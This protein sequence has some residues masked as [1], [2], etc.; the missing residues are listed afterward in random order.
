MPCRQE[1][2]YGRGVYLGQDQMPSAWDLSHVASLHKPGRSHHEAASR[3]L[4]GT[5]RLCTG[6]STVS[7]R[8]E[9]RRVLLDLN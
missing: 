9:S 7:M 4:Y 1:G 8:R 6:A 5:H 3:S 2:G